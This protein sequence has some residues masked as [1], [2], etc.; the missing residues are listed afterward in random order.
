M[1]KSN[2]YNQIPICQKCEYNKE[3]TDDQ[4]E[5]IISKMI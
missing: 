3:R 4:L 5:R 2:K 1:H